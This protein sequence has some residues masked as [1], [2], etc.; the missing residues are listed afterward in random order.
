MSGVANTGVK[1]VAGITLAMSV[2]QGLMNFFASPASAG[3]QALLTQL[4]TAL[5][6]MGVGAIVALMGYA[7]YKVYKNYMT[8]AAKACSEKGGTEKKMCMKEFEINAL[9]AQMN[10]MRKGMAACSKT[11]NSDKCREAIN[12]KVLKIKEKLDKARTNL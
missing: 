5:A 7:A 12:K 11:K 1:A 8:K 2:R 10:D 9:T 6:Y 3:V 4:T